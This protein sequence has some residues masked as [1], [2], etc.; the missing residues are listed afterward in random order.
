MKIGILSLIPGHNYGGILQ[1]YALQTFLEKKG[2]EIMIISQDH[3]V[4]EL[5]W[6]QKLY[7][8]PIRFARG[9]YRLRISSPNWE[10][11]RNVRD[12]EIDK[13]LLSFVDRHLH[14]FKVDSFESIP[15]N[16]FDALIVGSDQVWRPIYFKQQYRQAI[17]HAF[18]L[19]AKNWDIKRIAY[20][21]SF[22]VDEWEYSKEETCNC[23]QL[24]SL[25]DKISV[26]EYSG[27]DLCLKNL[28]RKPLCL[29]DP[30]MLVTC[31]EYVHNLKLDTLPKTKGNLFVYVLNSN[32]ELDSIVETLRTTH[33]L[34][35]FYANKTERNIKGVEVRPSIETWVRG[36]MDAEIVLTD[37]Y[38]ACVFS[39]L[40]HKPFI[41]IGNKYRGMARF[42]TL[43]ERFDLNKQMISKSEEYSEDLWKIDYVEVEKKILEYRKKS[44]DF[45]NF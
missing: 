19:F 24:I 33:S 36:V 37:S 11:V 4:P 1:S 13:G 21:P 28:G 14:I 44:M 8:F 6:L 20:A 7:T 18:L 39:I 2:H 40:F 41:V 15:E 29:I 26:R 43:L 22:A 17:E 31:E 12:V 3:L 9:L 5:S 10:R 25:F 35:P 23:R 32:E 38:H 30:T 45:L 42:N 27:I 34:I 16:I